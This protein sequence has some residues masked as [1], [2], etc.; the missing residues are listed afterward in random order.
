MRRFAVA[1]ALLV[2]ACSGVERIYQGPDLYD[3]VAELGYAARGGELKTVVR[4]NPFGAP[5]P[6]LVAAVTRAMYLSNRGR[7]VRFTTAPHEVSSLDYRVVMQFDVPAAGS[8][9]CAA[10]APLPP[11]PPGPT[12]R[13]DA[14]F[15][16]D[17]SALSEAWGEVDGATGPDDPAFQRLV[18]GVTRALF[19]PPRRNL[20]RDTMLWPN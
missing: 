18:S 16:R 13:L 4:G 1:L 7:V 6:A 8:E 3:T 2:G 15:C 11:R 14:A 19:P 17:R 9:L 12:V 5:E 10:T 20:R